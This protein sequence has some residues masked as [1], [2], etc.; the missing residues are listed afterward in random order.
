MSFSA[1]T[2]L[3][4]Y[5]TVGISV[6]GSV[7]AV[8][9][10]IFYGLLRTGHADTYIT[11]PLEHV[12]GAES[13][14]VISIKEQLGNARQ[15]QQHQQQQ[16]MMQPPPPPQQQSTSQSTQHTSFM[17]SSSSSSSLSSMNWAREGTYL[18][19]ATVLDSVVLPVKLAACLPIAQSILRRRGGR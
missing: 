1:K 4:T 14:T 11:T 16:Q 13:T 7:T 8:S 10:G 15:Q 3:Q 2:F 5:G 9:I 6:Y 17:L 12:L 18:G 19:I